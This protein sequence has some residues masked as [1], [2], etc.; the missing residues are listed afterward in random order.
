ME[1]RKDC[2]VDVDIDVLFQG[3]EKLGK[4]SGKESIFFLEEKK[5]RERKGGKYLEEKNIWKRKIFGD[6][7]YIFLPRRIFCHFFVIF[8]V[9]CEAG[10]SF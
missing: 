2:Y 3:E 8:P 5:N 9:F 4:Y 10:R 1:E 6:G 7:E